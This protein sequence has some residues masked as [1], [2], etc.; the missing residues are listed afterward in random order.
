MTN[1][2]IDFHLKKHDA[3]LEHEKE[4]ETERNAHTLY[5]IGLILPC[6]LGVIGTVCLLIYLGFIRP[7][8]QRQS[9]A[10]NNG[11]PN[12]SR[13]PNTMVNQMYIPKARTSD[14]NILRT[15]GY[16]KKEIV[17]AITNTTDMEMALDYIN[18]NT[19]NGDEPKAQFSSNVERNEE[20]VTT[21]L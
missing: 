14:Y 8:H 4:M 2:E 19:Q 21:W 17:K 3:K 10:S 1:T 16:N 7:K 20:M 11:I 6:I 15:M 5:K 12:E 9:N 18:Q 13:S